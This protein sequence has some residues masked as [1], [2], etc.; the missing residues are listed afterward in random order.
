MEDIVKSI[1]NDSVCHASGL[2]HI[3]CIQDTTEFCYDNNRGRFSEDDPHLGYGSNLKESFCIFAHPCLM[4]DAES[5]TPIGFSDINIYN[6]D[7]NNIGCKRTL[8]KCLLE[9]K[10]SYRWA[11]S[12]MRTSELLP[13]EIRKTIIGDRENDAYCIMHRT[14]ESNCDFL[15][16]SYV[17]RKINADF[18]YITNY[19]DRLPVMG[20]YKLKVR[21]NKNR[22]ARISEVE[23]RYSH[24][25]IHKPKGIK[26]DVPDTIDCY[27]VHARE[28]SAPDGESPIEWR[29]LTS[30][31]I[32][33]LSDAAQCLNWYKSRWTVEELFRLCKSEG[34]R[35]ESSQLGDGLS[36]KKM[37]AMTMYAALR[38]MTL[39]RAFDDC[40]EHIPAKRIFSEQEI[41]TLSIEMDRL[42]CQ[43]P[44]SKGGNNPFRKE[45]L[46]W[47][48]WIL[49]RLG[50]WKG[51]IA[52]D[53]P[54]YITMKNGLDVFQEHFEI[55]SFML[56][57]KT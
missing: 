51:Y 29:L 54:G 42:H 37:I 50:G 45:S 13:G 21:S 44:K 14:L 55:I 19:A 18:E 53:R 35:L 28:K 7:N 39:K 46:P 40:D 4:L 38:C 9:E 57:N 8:R 41:D 24:I 49:A 2:K 43:S 27:Y 47:A 26:D 25:S 32:D 22:S 23:V 17:N 31:K 34:Y 48:T 3:L 1:T 11:R 20:T 36:L 5:L 10:E 30:H 33:S 6:H 12:A 56:K 16:R 52:S 15:I